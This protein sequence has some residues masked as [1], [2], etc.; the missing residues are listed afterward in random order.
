MLIRTP[1]PYTGTGGVR[2]PIRSTLV[3]HTL[4]LS[5]ASIWMRTIGMLFQIWL[6]GHIGAA[7]IGLVQLIGT[8]G[9]LAATLG[10]AGVRVGAMYLI[11]DARGRHAS[12]RTVTACC[13]CYGAA[14]SCLAG[15]ALFA[16]APWISSHWLQAPEAAGPLRILATFLPAG[17]I[18]AVLGGWFTACVKIKQLTAVELLLQVLLFGVNIFLLSRASGSVQCCRI[19][20]TVNGLGDVAL[21]LILGLLYRRSQQTAQLEKTPGLWRKL[22]RLCVPLG[23][24]DLLRS[25]LSTTEH[26]LIPRGLAAYG[27]AH[28]NALAAYGTIHG[29]VFPVMMFP[30]TLLYAFS[31]LLVPEL[32]RCTA[33]GSERRVHYLTGRCLHLGAGYACTIAGAAFCLAKPLAELLYPGTQTGH[34][35]QLFAPLLGAAISGRDRGRHAQGLGS[36]GRLRLL[37]L[38]YC[39]AGYSSVAR[40]AAPLGHRRLLLGLRRLPQ[41]EFLPQHRSA[42]PTHRANA[43]LGL[44]RENAGLRRAVRPGLPDC[45]ASLGLPARRAAG[46]RRIPDT[47]RLP[48]LAKPRTAPRR[49]TLDAP[50]PATAKPLLIYHT[51][52]KPRRVCAA[53]GA[54]KV[55]IIFFRRQVGETPRAHSA[56]GQ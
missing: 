44:C 42:A 48:A 51:F 1:C 21:C 33:A 56:I 20:L 29:M 36:T 46:R 14:L 27:L 34:Y 41:C 28:G 53:H 45:A 5:V 52:K 7:G 47:A 23:L 31:D 9:I 30:A 49:P 43:G 25:S 32:A 10:T 37:Q 54:N 22:L 4:F 15:A 12:T 24:S 8:V 35:L 2:L 11:A 17:C 55:G 6:S 26:L 3:R 19:L 40:A 18:G 16:A 39:R 38:H 13:L 50:A